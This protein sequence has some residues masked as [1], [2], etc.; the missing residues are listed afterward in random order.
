MT[1][2]GI[3]IPM[4]MVDPKN[5]VRTD[6]TKP[7]VPLDPEWSTQIYG[8]WVALKTDPWIVLLFPMFFSSN[9]FY[10]W[11]KQALGPAIV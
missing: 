4:L 6:G 3:T 9:W 1:A 10:T 7:T 8:L 2:I 11:R 5:I